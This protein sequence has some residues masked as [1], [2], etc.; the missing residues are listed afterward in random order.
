MADKK[1]TCFVIMPISV[2][3]D[4]LNDYRGDK[5][6]FIHVLEHLFAPAIESIN[7]ELIPPNAKGADLIHAEIIKNLEESDLVICDMSTLNPNVFFELG[8]RTALNKPVCIVKDDKTPVIPFDMGIINSHTYLCGLDPW[9]LESEINKIKE[10]IEESIKRSGSENMLWRQFGITNVAKEYEQKAGDDPKMDYVMMQLDSIKQDLEIQK[11][12]RS[13]RKG[14][15][16]TDNIL[17]EVL[18]DNIKNHLNSDNIE[19]KSIDFIDEDMVIVTL[20]KGIV[21]PILARN[22]STIADS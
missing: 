1:K 19:I 21:T 20:P 11:N 7:Y 15:L 18:T 10:H 5:E 8:I 4:Q 9:I 6:H 22:L 12:E 16:P 3:G 2:H 13:K 14:V 17:R